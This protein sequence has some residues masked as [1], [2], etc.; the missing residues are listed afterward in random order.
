MVVDGQNDFVESEDNQRTKSATV[1]AT[2]GMGGRRYRLPGT[3][4]CSSGCRIL[5]SQHTLSKCLAECDN[6]KQT[7][8]AGTLDRVV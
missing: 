2:L 7:C 1:A 3:Y 6:H 4:I 5:V 8:S